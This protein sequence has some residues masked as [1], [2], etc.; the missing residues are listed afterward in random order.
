MQKNDFLRQVIA[1]DYPNYA[2][3][4]DNYRIRP[5]YKELVREVLVELGSEKYS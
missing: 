4:K 3:E 5:D 2:W 1:Y